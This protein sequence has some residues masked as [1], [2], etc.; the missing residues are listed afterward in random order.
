MQS[1][2]TDL[3]VLILNVRLKF[4]KG[5]AGANLLMML[6]SVYFPELTSL[7]TVGQDSRQIRDL[8]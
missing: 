5:R 2:V 8:A 1:T 7:L 6:P 3:P 4:V